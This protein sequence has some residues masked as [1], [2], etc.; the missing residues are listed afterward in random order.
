MT[1][2]QTGANRRN[3]Q[4]STG[5]KSHAGKAIVARNATTHGLL[6][7]HSVIKGELQEEFD[8][9]QAEIFADMKPVGMLEIVLLDKI[10][11]SLWQQQ[12]VP[13]IESEIMDAL[14]VPESEKPDKGL[15]NVDGV[16]IV[17]ASAPMV[18]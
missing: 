7:R 4:L 15:S 16:P 10:V 12:R 2:K 14:R 9:F 5:P 18:R 3:A 6:A 17:T 1:T 8:A 13:R 11:T